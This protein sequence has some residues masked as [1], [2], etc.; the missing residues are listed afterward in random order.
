MPDSYEIAMSLDPNTADNTADED[1]DFISN[2]DEYLNGSNPQELVWIDLDGDGILDTWEEAGSLDPQDSSDALLDQ[3]D[4]NGD[5]GANGIP[6]II[7]FQLCVY[8]VSLANAHVVGAESGLITNAN[9]NQWS[10]IN[11]ALNN[12]SNDD[13]VIIMPGTYNESVHI[14]NLD[15]TI[16]S[17][18][19][20]DSDIV[21]ATT[22]TN[23]WDAGYYYGLRDVIRINNSNCNICGLHFSWGKLAI[24]SNDSATDIQYCVMDTLGHKSGCLPD[25][26][27]TNYE[28]G[29]LIENSNCDSYTTIT[30]C[31][32][33]DNN[34]PYDGGAVQINDDNTQD[35]YQVIVRL[36]NTFLA[37]NGVYNTTSYV[38]GG[39]IANSGGILTVKGC[40]FCNNKADTGGAI[41]NSDDALAIIQNCTFVN[42]AA[43]VGDG[44]AIYNGVYY[45]EM[46]GTGE[47]LANIYS[48]IFWNNSAAGDGQE[49]A[50]S[51]AVAL[52]DNCLVDDLT[53]DA[54]YNYA[55]DFTDYI[56]E[57]D[58]FDSDPLFLSFEDPNGVDGV[59]GTDDDGLRI[60]SGSPCVDRAFNIS[61]YVASGDPN[62]PLE[63]IEE[64]LAEDING[65]QRVDI[66]NSGTD[67]V[68]AADIGA[69]EA[70]LRW[71]V[72]S[73]S[74]AGSSADGLSWETAFTTIDEAL[75]ACQA[76][77]ADIWVA[78]GEY[79]PDSYND[80]G[81]RILNNV[82][83][84]GGFCGN[85]ISL[86]QRKYK[87]NLTYI[88]GKIE[89]DGTIFACDIAYALIDGFIIGGSSDYAVDTLR[90]TICFRHCLFDTESFDCDI[91][92][93]S[94]NLAIESCEIDSE[95][96][97]LTKRVVKGS[98]STITLSSSVISAFGTFYSIVDTENSALY[99]VR[100]VFAD[101]YFSQSP[102]CI[103]RSTSSDAIVQGCIFANNSFY[104][105]GS[106]INGS[107]SDLEIYNCTFYGNQ[108]YTESA[109]V[110]ISDNGEPIVK[111]SIFWNNDIDFQLGSVEKVEFS[112]IQNMSSGFGGEANVSCDPYFANPDNISGPDGK[113]GTN[114]DGLHL[115]CFRSPAWKS[116][117]AIRLIL[118]RFR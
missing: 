41:F 22:L 54:L 1:H 108:S 62:N 98:S 26:T 93:V 36:E 78:A 9:I 37:D 16:T 6:D 40:V 76:N 99:L 18:N 91:N 83:L 13:L 88:N 48:S 12:C 29:I 118:Y 59:W 11:A 32:F 19:P 4:S 86:D 87:E 95:G 117:T 5:S 34:S 69:Y 66:P 72:N 30:N 55:A 50:N 15:L 94:S 101:S 115:H 74:S 39:A 82:K 102:G 25:T 68:P 35:S 2:A 104:G 51:E 14:N 46:F 92:A 112:C 111:N 71:Y 21:N 116:G 28:G 114:D 107:S 24:W 65:K 106:V 47:S 103:V 38:K 97:S 52:I 100:N 61:Y 63:I 53:G 45:E 84:Y 64:V 31:I 90:S 81:L 80:Y 60:I 67:G 27:Y 8:G 113:W 42:N 10:T 73:N 44:G 49:L 105:S 110:T 79:T 58:C 43:V 109:C 33:V 57:N 56:S 70:D 3:V 96:S 75:A 89:N 85:E 17:L 20:H 7:D 77:S 23:Y